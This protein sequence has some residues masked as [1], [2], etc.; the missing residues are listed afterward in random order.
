MNFSEL[1]QEPSKLK[2]FLFHL[3]GWALVLFIFTFIYSRI[4]GEWLPAFLHTVITLPVYMAPTYYL[5]YFIV[6]RLLISKQYIRALTHGIYLILS[7]TFF[8]I[9][10][11]IAI[12]MMP[13]PG[14]NLDITPQPESLDVFSHLVGVFFIAFLVSSARLYKLRDVEAKRVSALEKSNLEAEMQMLKGQ[15]HPHF[16]FNTLNSIY[17]LA[18]KKSSETPDLIVKLSELLDY[19]LYESQKSAITIQDEVKI[20][21]NYI[22]LEQKRYG[23][24]LSIDFNI[25]L[26]KDDEMIAPL[27]LL[28]LVENAFKHGAGKVSGKASINIDLNFKAGLLEFQIRNNK[29]DIIKRSE[30]Q[31]GGIGLKNLQQRLK[32][33]Y[34]DQ[35]ELIISDETESYRV[36]LRINM[37]EI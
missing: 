11:S 18:L 30:D 21:E 20:L 7:T 25:S 14:L 36:K 13:V 3:L 33:I 31:S 35:H 17:A 8:Y 28:P 26:E 12:I 16:L 15:L 32:L 27:L 5:S 1:L 10:L 24:R 34:S 19:T 6:P 4:I 22:Q 23:D 9:L 37:G 2:T 29:P